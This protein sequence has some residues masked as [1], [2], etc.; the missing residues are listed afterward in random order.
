MIDTRPLRILVITPDSAIADALDRFANEQGATLRAALSPDEATASGWD[1]VFIDETHP[2]VAPD[3]IPE[4]KEALPR[5]S[6]FWITTEPRGKA[7]GSA[8]AHG[9][10]DT[11]SAPLWLPELRARLS[12]HFEMVRQ[13]RDSG[14][15]TDPVASGN[16]QIAAYAAQLE[17]SQRNLRAL[18]T[19]LE[20]QSRDLQA[21]LTAQ[22]ALIPLQSIDE[23]ASHLE[24]GLRDLFPDGRVRAHLARSE[25]E[26]GNGLTRSVEEDPGGSGWVRARTPVAMGDTALGALE[27]SAPA[28]QAFA[29][30]RIDLLE[31][32][33]AQAAQ[34]LHRSRL[35]DALSL[36]K[37]EWERTFDTIADSITIIGPRFEIRRANRAVA[38]SVGKAPQDLIGNPCFEVVGG[39]DAPC[40]E[41]PAV[42]ALETGEE[43]RTERTV[44]RGDQRYDYRAYPLKDETG[45]VY[46]AIVYTRNVTKEQQLE[47]SL[48]QSEKLMTLGQIA[49]GIAHEINNPLTAVSS[50][51]QLLGLRLA[52]PKAIE[53]ARGIEQGIER[54]HRLVQNL[55]I[56]VRPSSDETF[57]PLDLNE[58]ATDTLSF[59]R[60][61]VTRG[62][63]ELVEDLQPSL[64]KVL[65]S[66]GQLE[67]VI[68][69]LLTN[70][71]DAVAGCG[72]IV[73]STRSTEATVT[74]EVVDDGMGIAPEQGDKVFEPFY[75][76]K[77]VGSGTGLGLFTAAGIVRK[78]GGELTASS[79]PGKGTR[80]T[81][82]LPTFDL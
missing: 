80:F 28:G 77:P 61:E 46:A 58:I 79:E 2:D 64:P 53:C 32:Y 72:T 52:D 59:S 27:V 70:A 75:T 49:A 20:T 62:D 42:Q 25:E 10:D 8:L 34:A 30:R 22:E 45:R 31:V 71:R 35:Y 47:R 11:V 39:T 67:H 29:H 40:A 24:A 36:G 57:Y 16:A 9:A 73:V 1:V 55:M 12:R 19:E 51:A 4:I 44:G 41:C 5:T 63:T 26:D 48:R 15:G 7:A 23:T 81:L 56:F 82:T 60:Y 3:V 69:S 50:Y 18:H 13:I 68:L 43:A 76:T 66:K 38:S 78:H 54:I 14:A 65:G 74:F 6:L 21:L 37:A 33:A 17:T